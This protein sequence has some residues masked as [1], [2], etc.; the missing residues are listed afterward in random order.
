VAQ[1]KRGERTRQVGLRDS[2]ARQIDMPIFLMAATKDKTRQVVCKV[3][4]SK[5]GHLAPVN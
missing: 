5:G 2:Q 1:N 3:V 4:L